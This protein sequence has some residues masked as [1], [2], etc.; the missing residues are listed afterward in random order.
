MKL[1]KKI[2]RRA[3]DRKFSVRVIDTVDKVYSVGGIETEH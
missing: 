2:F 3:P 1:P